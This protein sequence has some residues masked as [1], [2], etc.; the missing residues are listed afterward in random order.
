[1]SHTVSHT[2]EKM[3]KSISQY[4]DS[5][6]DHYSKL[7]AIRIDL[8][9]SKERAQQTQLSDI[10]QDVKRMLDNRRGKPSIFENQV[11]YVIKYED[12][13]DKGPH[14]HALFLYDGQHVQKDGYRGDQL[15]LYWNERITEGT[16]VYHNCN[17]DK[18]KYLK[19]GIGMIDHSDTTKR[20]NLINHVVPYMLKAEQSIDGI[21]QT[22]KEKSITKGIAPKTKSST[23]RPRASTAE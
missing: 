21:R 17:R 16:G 18:K 23:G 4:L 1:M 15:G 3:Q 12:T 13:P 10:K 6:H 8:G 14:A 7:V 20:D 5:L 22:G 19:C 11:G 2:N 9:Y